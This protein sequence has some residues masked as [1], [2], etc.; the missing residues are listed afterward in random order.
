MENQAQ[1]L[2]WCSIEMETEPKIV[3]QPIEFWLPNLEIVLLHMVRVS[4]R[5]KIQKG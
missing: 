2:K 5:E 1:Y 3:I 4:S